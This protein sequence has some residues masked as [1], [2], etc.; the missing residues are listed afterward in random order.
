MVI[1]FGVRHKQRNVALVLKPPA[2]IQQLCVR[3]VR[4]VPR[5]RGI[6]MCIFCYAM[7]CKLYA[8]VHDMRSPA[9]GARLHRST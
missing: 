3:H 8:V 6:L 7:C 4:V 2:A 9:V 1:V 5:E